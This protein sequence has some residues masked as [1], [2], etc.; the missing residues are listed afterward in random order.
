[1]I[2]PILV[3]REEEVAALRD[4]ASSGRKQLA[5]L[6]GRRQ[7]GK[8]YLLTHAWDAALRPFYFLAAEQ[9]SDLNRQDLIR[10]LADWSGRP[11]QMEDFP[12]WRTVFREFFDLATHGPVVAVLDEFQYLLA[13]GQG[14]TSQLVASWDRAPLELPIVLVLSGSEVT[15]MAHLNAGSEPLFGRVTWTKELQPFDYRDAAR[16]V[17]WLG[18]RDAAYLYGIFGG[19]PRYLAALRDNEPL[20]DGAVRAFVA[21]SGEVHLQLL[22]LVEQ[23]TG[24][25]QPAE[26]RAVLATVAAGNTKLNEIAQACGLEDYVV[27]RVLNVLELQLRLVRG[28]Q[29]FAA[30]RR[31]PYHYRITDNATA[32]WHTFLVPHRSRLATGEDCRD[33]W[34]EHIIPRLDTYMGHAFEGIV[35]EAYT[36]YHRRWHLPA[37]RELGRW[38]GVDRNRESVEIDLVGHLEDGR[39]LVGEI[40]W[41]S[42]P[43]G[44]GLHSGLLDKLRRLALSGQGWARDRADTVYLYAAAAGFTPGMWRLAE[45]NPQL[46]L[47]TLEDLY[48]EDGE[49]RTPVS[50]Q[51]A[52][53]S[54][55]PIPDHRG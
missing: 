21:S 41:S 14:V 38:E 46:R 9:T 13:D 3:D 30:A 10:D 17:P 47:L 49:A 24:I 54:A 40:K 22:T 18:L 19:A 35:H 53:A 42:S 2:R 28:E 51:G 37:A 23:I 11:L 45:D 4:L 43:H 16:M 29:N 32:F 34:D 25:R 1:M 8:T 36:R 55:R 6:Y 20:I 5:I 48:P 31:A 27:R 26:Y 12:T 52:A 50:P 15:T 39:L 7:V 33:F 44:P